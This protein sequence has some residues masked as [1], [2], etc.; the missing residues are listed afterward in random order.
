M[1]NW[2]QTIRISRQIWVVI[3]SSI[4]YF[5]V[6]TQTS[7]LL[8]NPV[9]AQETLRCNLL[10]AHTWH[11]RIHLFVV[12]S[13]CFFRFSKSP[14]VAQSY[15]LHSDMLLVVFICFVKLIQYLIC[16]SHDVERTFNFFSWALFVQVIIH[17][18]KKKTQHASSQ[19][20]SALF[21]SKKVILP[22]AISSNGIYFKSPA[23]FF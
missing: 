18:T 19:G 3:T 2:F 7:L 17:L 6:I 13:D 23:H 21:F 1:G 5:E 14:I 4:G 15:T 9:L 20:N 12:N 8:G 11:G 10:A 16:A 22:Q